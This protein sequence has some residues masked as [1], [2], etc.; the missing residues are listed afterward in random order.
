MTTV[1]NWQPDA[2]G[3]MAAVVAGVGA[4][5]S[6]GF[7]SYVIPDEAMRLLREGHAAPEVM[8]RLRAWDPDFDWPGLDERQASALCYT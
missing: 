4:V 1:W 5:M 7:A 8:A 3:R 2:A 6:Q